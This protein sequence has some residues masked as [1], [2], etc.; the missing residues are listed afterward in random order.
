MVDAVKGKFTKS[1]PGNRVVVFLAVTGALVLSGER[2]AMQRGCRGGPPAA[3]LPPPPMQCLTWHGPLDTQR[4][5]GRSN[6]RVAHQAGMLSPARQAPRLPAHLLHAPTPL[7][8]RPGSS[9]R[10]SHC[11]AAPHEQKG[12]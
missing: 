6:V 3:L 7:Q 10:Y 1:A 5:E 4:S 8:R 2:R 9:P 12:V 11:S